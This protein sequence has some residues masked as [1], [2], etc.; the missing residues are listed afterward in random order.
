M[1]IPAA[2]E[3]FLAG[4]HIPVVP[5]PAYPPET[6]RFRALS[7]GS[8]NQI[9]AVILGQDPYHG[10]GQATGLAFSV[11]AGSKIPPSL[12][13]IFSE[14]ENDPAL[15]NEE[16]QDDFFN[17]ADLL[18]GWHQ[19]GVM[20]LN[21]ALSVAPGKAASHAKIGWEP[22][23]DKIISVISEQSPSCV[24]ILWGAH[25]QAKKSLID[26]TKHLVIESVHPSPLSAHRGFFGSRPFSRT[27]DWLISK[28]V[29][30]VRW[31]QIQANQ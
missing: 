12:R 18:S 10:A 9:R 14:I 22:F 25:A 1:S 6:L 17:S 20:L 15:A 28:G 21:T 31:K 2:W 24:F 11:P 29:P 7:A 5:S 4:I 23:T 27:N 13:N 30:T 8:P 19:Q 3:P 16:R 26:T